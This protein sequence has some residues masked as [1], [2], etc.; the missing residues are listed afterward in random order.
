MSV[1]VLLLRAA[2]WSQY[3]NIRDT[4]PARIG[5]FRAVVLLALIVSCHASFTTSL[6]NGDA[7]LFMIRAFLKENNITTTYNVILF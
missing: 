5:M 1:F 7:P 2:R 6:R 3:N 4:E